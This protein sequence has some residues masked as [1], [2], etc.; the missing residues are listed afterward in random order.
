[1]VPLA[2]K[3][4]LQVE[5]GRGLHGPLHPFGP[6]LLRID[7]ERTHRLPG[8]EVPAA[9]EAAPSPVLIAMLDEPFE[10]SSDI[11]MVRVSETDESPR[12]VAGRAQVR[13]LVALDDE[14]SFRTVVSTDPQVPASLDP[15][16]FLCQ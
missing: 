3:F 14:A 4:P 10:H 8:I 7:G 6:L 16:S 12:H 15:R 2:M 1:M 5:F 9:P 13:F 11:G